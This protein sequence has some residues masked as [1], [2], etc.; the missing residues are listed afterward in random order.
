ML[1]YKNMPFLIFT[2]NININIIINNHKSM[3]YYRNAL[4]NIPLI[5]EQYKNLEYIVYLKKYLIPQ[6]PTLLKAKQNI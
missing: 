5:V 2:K 4:K 1:R 3:S 6:R